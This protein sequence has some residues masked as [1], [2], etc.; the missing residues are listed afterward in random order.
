[1]A[2]VELTT[3]T[4]HWRVDEQHRELLLDEHG[5]R[6][7]EWLQS[8]Q[9]K[10]VKHAAH[11]TVYQ[12]HL[13]GLHFYLKRNRAADVRARLRSWIRPGK[14]LDEYEHALDVARRDVPTITPLAAGRPRHGS[15]ESFLLTQALENTTQLNHFLEL[16]LPHFPEPRQTRLRQRITT[17][18]G[19]LLARMHEAG[20]VHRD[21]HPGNILLQLD[22]DDNPVLY[23][24]D[25]HGVALGPPLDWRATRDNLVILNRWFSLRASKM[26]RLRCWN[27]Y[28]AFRCAKSGN[29]QKTRCTCPDRIREIEKQTKLSNLA[30]W[31]AHDGRCRTNNRRFRRVS[32]SGVVGHAVTDLH[33][34]TLAALLRD[35]DAPF[36]QPG[37]K[38]YKDSRS[39]TVAEMTIT[40]QGEPRRVIWKR[41]RVTSWT[42]PLLALFR[43][44]GAM[45][46]WVLGHG[47]RLRWLPTPRPLLVL[48]R[49]RLGLLR[50]GY[51]LAAKVEDAEELHD[52]LLRLA[53]MPMPQRRA[54][55]RPVL[56]TVAR[57]IRDLHER[58]LSH[59]D[60]KAP[61]LLVTRT[62]DP[63]LQAASA[64]PLDHWPLTNSRVWFIDL[65]GVRAQRWLSHG[66][67]IKDLARLAVSSAGHAFLSHGDRLRFLR[68]YLG[69]GWNGKVDWKQSWRQ[70]AQ[71]AQSKLAR[72]A[73]SGRPLA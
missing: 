33:P 58:R 65:V 40:L 50:E 7:E 38:L 15:G 13:P 63:Q 19:A 17:A 55:L 71:A 23:L 27:A 47:M 41:F 20:I 54:E 11:R 16:E 36:R 48:H 46:S 10:V 8:G 22:A 5:L 69:C 9:A 2:Y 42:D 66:R 37:V 73:R 61:N 35:P 53:P 43:P 39:A 56:E 68:L 1:M 34:D 57:L 64:E 32:A 62:V 30:F 72:N 70:I 29:G 3:E 25:L 28:C 18:L 67:R 6:L 14:A 52:F 51:L 60:L 21:L 44:T 31:R 12:V 26:D 45:R 49:K 59:R 24:I 4:M